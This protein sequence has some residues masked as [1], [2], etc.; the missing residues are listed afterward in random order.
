MSACAGGSNG[1]TICE[2]TPAYHRPRKRSRMRLHGWAGLEEDIGRSG[3]AEPQRL[4]RPAPCRW[5]GPGHSAAAP[6]SSPATE[7]AP[8]PFAAPTIGARSQES[9]S[10][11]S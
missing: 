4:P 9:I 11:N 2:G 10:A 8:V 1:T 3:V 7:P 6:L 5:N